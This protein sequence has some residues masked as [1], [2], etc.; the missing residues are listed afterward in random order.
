M[1]IFIIWIVVMVLLYFKAYQIVHFGYVQFVI[2][3]LYINESD[4]NIAYGYLKANVHQAS[5]FR[6]WGSE[7]FKCNIGSMKDSKVSR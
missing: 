6:G 7:L 3:Q 1:G 5:G 2:C 4:K